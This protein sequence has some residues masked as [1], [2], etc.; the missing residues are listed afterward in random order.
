MKKNE[1]TRKAVDEL[2]DITEAIANNMARARAAYI[3]DDAHTFG[4]A[5][6]E[7][8]KLASAILRRTGTLRHDAGVSIKSW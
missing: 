4:K 6:H 2:R 5:L 1:H 8:D 3:E 7:V